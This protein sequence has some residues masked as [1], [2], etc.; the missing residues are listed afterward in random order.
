MS[1]IS[2]GHQGEIVLPDTVRQRYG[3]KPNDSVRMIETKMG[4]L[5]IPITDE[6]MS[7]SLAAELADWQE[8]GESSRDLFAFEDSPG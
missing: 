2:L 1:Q 5:I 7:E 8:L 4:V 6:P 3:F